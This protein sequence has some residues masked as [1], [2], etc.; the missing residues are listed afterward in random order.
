MNLKKPRIF[1]REDVGTKFLAGKREKSIAQ[2]S[3]H[4]PYVRKKRNSNNLPDGYDDTKRIKIPKSWKHRVRKKRQW[5]LHDK[6]REVI[7]H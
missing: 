3:M 5:E 6:K 4:K 2:D 7:A 1:V